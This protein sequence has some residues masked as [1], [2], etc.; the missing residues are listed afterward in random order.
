M[1]QSVRDAFI[2]F[3]A[4][5]EG[6]VQ[7]M[8]LDIKSLVSTGVGNLLDAD[9]PQHFGTNPNPLPDIFTLGWHD[10]DTLAPATRAEILQEYK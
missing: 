4:P 7:F 5:L 1:H 8:Y 10:K 9:D 6:R 2:P 3:N